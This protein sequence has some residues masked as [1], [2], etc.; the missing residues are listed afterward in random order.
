VWVARELLRLLERVVVAVVLAVAVGEL[1]SLTQAGSRTHR[2]QVSF[3]IVGAIVVALGAMGGNSS[4]ARYRQT[5]TRWSVGY[6]SGT[7]PSA[8]PD[9]PQ[10]APGAV[11]FLSG[12]VVLVLG[13]LL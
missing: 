3:L 12:A 10:L 7:L 1:W 6:L 13:L 5:R 4:Y 8:R 11:L 9:E 2:L